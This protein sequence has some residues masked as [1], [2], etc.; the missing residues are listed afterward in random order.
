M[1]KKR[2]ALLTSILALLL[3]V[4]MLVGTTFAWFTDSVSSGSNVIAAGVLDV[5]LEQLVDGKWIPV[6]ESTNVFDEDAL[7]EPGYTQVVY[8]RV[9]NAG[10]LA[11]KY[12]LGVNIASETGSVN[13]KG[14]P[15]VLSDYIEYGTVQGVQT[16]FASREAAR[17]AVTET[18]IL[19]NG[20]A[21]Q[22]TLLPGAEPDYLALVVFM[23]ETVENDANYATGAPAPQINLGIQLT[24]TQQTE[25]IDSFDNQ[26]DANAAADFF[27]G[28][29]GG[30]AG[31]VVERG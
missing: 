10:D 11:L 30:A 14:N 24:A 18:S 4:S 8:L 15:F 19:S 25:E 2:T 5:E 23:P 16:P 20:Y 26:Y 12:Q 22:E 7:W 28:F 17:A 6:N 13:V 29:Q 27:P 3:C 1:K 21:Q 31:A 9:R